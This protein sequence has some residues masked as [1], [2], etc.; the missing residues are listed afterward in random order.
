[1]GKLVALRD[2]CSN[3]A[4]R[5][6]VPFAVGFGCTVAWSPTLVMAANASNAS[7]MLAGMPPHGACMPSLLASALTCLVMLFGG[8]R[9]FEALLRAVKPLLLSVLMALIGGV[10][11]LE[12]L[13]RSPVALLNT[14]IIAVA[15]VFVVM[16]YVLWMRAFGELS[17]QEMLIT[18]LL[19]QIITCGIN[20]ALE[21][22]YTIFAAVIAFPFVSIACLSTARERVDGNACETGV[23]TDAS[24]GALLRLWA[25]L[26]VVVLGWG[27]V[28]HLF[29]GGFDALVQ[30]DVL[31]APVSMAYH[32]AAFV[33]VALAIGFAFVLFASKDRFNF[34]HVYRMV[35][36]LGLTSIVAFPV[37]SPG[38]V[39]V[40]GYS[41]SVVMYQLVF[42]LVW[43]ASASA[44]RN[45][46]A[47]ASGYFGLVFG[48]WSLGSF[49]GAL[50]SSWQV[51][52]ISAQSAQVTVFVAV[53]VAAVGYAAVFTEHDANTLINIIPFK[54]KMPFREK[55]L[56]VAGAH[57]LSPRETEIAMLIAQ[58]RDSA[59]I[60]K[61]LFLSRS[62]VQTHRMHI[63]QKLDIHNRQELLDMIEQAGEAK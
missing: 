22:V 52:D 14:G 62:T 21:S 55:C 27:A 43:V 39:A 49:L 60:Q 15:G 30:M 6:N 28:D 37:A 63:Y 17:A 51:L 42:L 29:R 10:L 35:F 56:A 36:L 18:L 19:S 25:K 3:A 24:G 44:F 48:C 9:L 33:V 31:D 57:K 47:R 40:A 45:R 61:K 54:R 23:E 41:F 32:V 1:M 53:L 20:A 16:L 12:F 13:S 4:R 46:A 59:H 7:S 38:W 34:G 26:A 8:G 5:V 2:A 58:G 50:L 11:F